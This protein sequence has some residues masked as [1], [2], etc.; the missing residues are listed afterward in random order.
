M[1][2]RPL[3]GLGLALGA[4]LAGVGCATA[5]LQLGVYHWIGHEPLLLGRDQRPM[6]DRAQIHQHDDASQVL[7]VLRQGRLDGAA[8]T[9]DETLRARGDGVPLTVVL[10]LDTSAGAD[11]LLAHDSVPTLADLRGRRVGVERSA[12][13]ALMLAKVLQA[14]AL[15]MAD[16]QVLDLAPQALLA[17]WHARRIDAAVT[18]E[19]VASQL[20]RDGARRLFDSRS[21]PQTIFDVLAVRRD[22]LRGSG[23][24]LRAVLEA[25]FRG[26]RHLRV[27][28]TDAVYRIATRNQVS[29]AEVAR[30][31][32]GVTL[33]DLAGNKALLA[34]APDLLAAARTL[35]ELLPSLG[36]LKQP[37]SLTDLFDGDHLPDEEVDS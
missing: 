35:N 20:L 30:A 29:V 37:D 11:M 6:P 18:Y 31:L 16:V 14:A 24:A 26:L 8:L 13:G 10:V 17:A 32:A 25:H 2:R 23:A 34:P 12:V 4:G 15:Q 3:I 36:L 21:L 33:P 5:P 27:N 22:R 9:L 1:N 28:R 19:P 7:A